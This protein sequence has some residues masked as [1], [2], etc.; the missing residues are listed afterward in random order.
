MIGLW[1][2]GMIDIGNKGIGYWGI[3]ILLYT[4]LSIYLYTFNYM[5]G[6]VKKIVV[7]DSAV[8]AYELEEI[9]LYGNKVLTVL[10]D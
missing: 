6:Q 8:Y 1:S 4:F 3:R 7:S 5:F 2:N 9:V 10:P